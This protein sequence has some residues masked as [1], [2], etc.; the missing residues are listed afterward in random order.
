MTRKRSIKIDSDV[1]AS[2]AAQPVKYMIV[3]LQKYLSI[4]YDSN[5]E[6]LTMKFDGIDAD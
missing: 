1:K 6:R 3:D 5:K 2:L 4:G